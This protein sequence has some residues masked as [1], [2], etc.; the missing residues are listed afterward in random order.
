MSFPIVG[1][2]ASAGGLESFSELIAGIPAHTGM[3]YVFVQHL[4]PRRGS[5]LVNILT[6]RATFS[7]EEARKGVKV[8][9]DHL[10]VIAPNTTLTIGVRYRT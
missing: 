3:A 1:I 7:V 4:N 10:Y 9:P 8:L 5:L 2:G 6:K